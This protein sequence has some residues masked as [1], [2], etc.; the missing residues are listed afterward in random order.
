MLLRRLLC[1]ASLV[2]VCHGGRAS[3]DGRRPRSRAFDLTISWERYAPDGFARDMLLVNGQS[4]GPVL[5]MEQDDWVVVRVRNQSPFNTSVHFHGIDQRDTPWSDGVPGVTQRPIAPGRAFTYR[6]R[7]AQYGSYWYHAHARAQI[8]DGLYGA[9]VV[10]PRDEL[11]RPFHLISEAPA[12]V[13]AMRRAERHVRPLVLYDLMHLTSE[14]RAEVAPRA[15]VETTCYDAILFNGKGRVTCL[16]QEDMMANL[17]P[18]QRMSL[19]A[20]PGEKLTD[21]G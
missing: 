6:F 17:T 9:V 7:A 8:E 13:R 2:L 16:R 21:K 14:Q 20:V 10:H 15:G 18:G 4:P 1:I 3:P 12:A 11:P 5:E 19:G